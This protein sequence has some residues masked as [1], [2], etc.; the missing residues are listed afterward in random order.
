MRPLPR[1][2][3]HVS[4]SAVTS[5]GAPTFIFEKRFFRWKMENVAGGMVSTLL[6]E[7]GGVARPP[8]FHDRDVLLAVQP[9]L[10]PGRFYWSMVLKAY[11]PPKNTHNPKPER[12]HVSRW[13]TEKTLEGART[14]CFE[15]FIAYRHTRDTVPDPEVA[16]LGL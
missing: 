5:C 6:E 4:D 12:P 9:D 2:V 8:V 16:T 7:G 1:P 13:G 11:R 3:R 10:E 14:A 15:A